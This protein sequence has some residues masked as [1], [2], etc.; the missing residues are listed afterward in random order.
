MGWKKTSMALCAF[1]PM[2]FSDVWAFGWDDLW[3]RTDQQVDQL[4]QDESFEAAAQI[5]QTVEQNA[6]VQYRAGDYAESALSYEQMDEHYNRGTALTRAGDY[7]AAIEA[8]DQIL[9][10]SGQYQDAVHNRKIAQK[11]AELQQQQQDQGQGEGQNE[12]ESPPSE[13]QPNNS[14]DSSGGAGAGDGDN[15]EQEQGESDTNGNDIPPDQESEDSNPSPS[16]EDPSEQNQQPQPAQAEPHDEQQQAM[17]QL[18][19]R[20]PDD[21]AGLLKARIIREH[22]RNYGGSRDKELAW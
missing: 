8:F 11:L 20:V 6:R 13:D 4:I 1:L 19:Q 18:L 21:P 7:Q 15:N 12:Q 5:A 3:T 17:D 10:D 16:G 14:P 2:S 22:Q 9:S